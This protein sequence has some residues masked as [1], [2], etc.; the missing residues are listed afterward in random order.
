MWSEALSRR[1]LRIRHKVVQG[2]LWPLNAVGDARLR[3]VLGVPRT[4]IHRILVCRPNHRLGNLLLL[5]PLL[6]ELARALPWATVDLLV[7]GEAG[8][9]LFSTWANVGH[10]YV[11]SRRT[12]HH[13]LATLGTIWR[14]R[15]ARYDLA[16][17]PCAGSQS[18]RAVAVLA[19][20]RHL[21]GVPRPSCAAAWAAL[22]PLGCMSQHLAQLPVY[23]LRRAL[24]YDYAQ[25]LAPC[26]VLDLRLAHDE[27][28]HARAVLAKQLQDA[29]AQPDTPV[30]GVFGGATGGKRYTRDWW[31]RF[32]GTL[33]VHRP[34]CILLEI[35]PPDGRP[36]LQLALPTYCSQHLR[37]VAAVLSNLTA[38]VSADCGVMHLA[39]ASGTPTLA[40]FSVSSAGKYAP[41]GH[42]SGAFV[43]TGKSPEELARYAVAWLAGLQGHGLDHSR[44][45]S[46]PGCRGAQPTVSKVDLVPGIIEPPFNGSHA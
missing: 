14:L 29:G 38:F 18:G 13:P 19:N 33:R 12:I 35:L 5:T 8:R 40:L 21:L 3:V 15:R 6:A 24:A 43:T 4:R 16:I 41:Y 31:Q 36:C 10:V 45:Q 30:V 22:D 9:E 7:A 25:L 32:V 42:G 39:S 1:R 28:V 34:D 37:Q 17:D 44:A 26:P 23:L 11:L 46:V 2:L 27:R 20:A